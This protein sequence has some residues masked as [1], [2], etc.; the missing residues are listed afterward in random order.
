MS[1]VGELLFEE[2][3][4]RRILEIEPNHSLAYRKR[5]TI[6]KKVNESDDTKLSR[7][8]ELLTD[9]NQQIPNDHP[10][11]LKARINAYIERIYNTLAIEGNT[12]SKEEVAR[13]LKGGDGVKIVGKSPDEHAE[14]RGMRDAIKYLEESN[15]TIDQI[16]LAE[17]LKIHK[18][19]LGGTTLAKYAGKLRS[20]QVYITNSC[21]V[22]VE[23]K[24]VQDEMDNYVEWLRNRGGYMDQM[25]VIEFAA[26]AHY[27]MAYIHP[28]RDG[29][30]R[31]SRVF[32]NLILES[33]GF[34]PVGIPVNRKNEYIF[35]I[36]AANNGEIREHVRFIVSQIGITITDLLLYCS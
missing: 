20:M 11:L 7:C 16:T 27:K 28:F 25:D 17:I 1:S 14:I 19:I 34:P 36:R 33:N 26:L 8:Y 31:I 4:Y 18:F 22:P 15:V 24:F 9:F 10:K 29:N 35:S 2:G 30:G 23:A 5:Y 21:F 12:M 13:V 6:L 32:M 3:C